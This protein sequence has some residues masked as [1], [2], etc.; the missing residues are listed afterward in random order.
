MS[1]TSYRRPAIDNVCAR[2]D[3]APE[4]RPSTF[5][6]RRASTQHQNLPEAQSAWRTSFVRHVRIR[7]NP[8]RESRPRV[9][10]TLSWYKSIEE[11]GRHLEI[12]EH[13][14]PL[15]EARFVVMTIEVRA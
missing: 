10:L 1:L 15:A 11:R 3:F 5:S 4:P 8:I 7:S 13:A 2:S 9:A 14:W 12:A 6:L